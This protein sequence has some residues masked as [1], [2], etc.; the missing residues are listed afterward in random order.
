MLNSH[1]IFH[2]KITIVAAIVWQLD[3]NP[4]MQTMPFIFFQLGVRLS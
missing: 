4:P 3:R 2:G 1:N